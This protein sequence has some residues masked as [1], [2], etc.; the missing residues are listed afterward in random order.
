MDNVVVM[1]VVEKMVLEG[2]ALAFK[3]GN[4]DGTGLDF[5][6][7]NVIGTQHPSTLMALVHETK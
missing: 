3:C 7:R 2:H 6:H 5:L 1:V 4:W